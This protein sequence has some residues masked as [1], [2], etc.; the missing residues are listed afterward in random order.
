[1]PAVVLL[2]ALLLAQAKMDPD[3]CAVWQR[4]LSFAQSVDNH[5]A[6]AFAAHLHPG[7][8]FAAGT[9]NPVRGAGAV[10]KDWASLIEGKPLRLRWRPNSVN[11]GGNRN[12]AIS[13]GPYM[14]EDTRPGAKT[15][16]RIGTFLT[17]WG[18]KSADAP[19]LVLFDGGGAAATPVDDLATAE[20]FMAQAPASCSAR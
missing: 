9:E 6:K 18:R 17:I 3:E 8:V 1:M 14:M 19:W 16:Y 10:L 20:K 15:K 12:V 13:R 7:T 5:N 11:I 2:T 4:E